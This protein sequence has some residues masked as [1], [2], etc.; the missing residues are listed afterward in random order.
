MLLLNLG[1]IDIME[2]DSKNIQSYIGSLGY[3][4][5]D[6]P[7]RDVVFIS[8][9]TGHPIL[10]DGRTR[11]AISL[12]ID[13]VNLMANIGSGYIQTNFLFSTGNWIYDTKLDTVYLENQADNLLIESGWKYQNNRWINE[14]GNV[15][16]FSLVV[17]NNY[18]D[19]V[20]AANTIAEQ[21]ANHGIEV[22]VI[23][24]GSQAFEYTFN[25]KAYECMICG[26]HTGFSPKITSL[27]NSNSLSN[28]YSE[29]LNNVLIDI[30]TTT[31]YS[32]Q[33]ENYSRL[34]DQYLKEFPYVFL[35]RSTSSV[36]YNQTLC[37][38]ISPNNYSMFYNIEKW[39]RQ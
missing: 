9:N 8:F 23:E 31:D 3:T 28:F 27:F 18:P 22:T 1:Y 30:K 32:K 34:Y 38:K 7:E 37:G 24:Q 35:Y 16:A 39:Y 11:K 29:D 19:R 25:N 2:V 13:R 20:V 4:K 33:K 26:I 36:I 17:D 6:I 12:Y 14:L 5:V 15:L 10:S 21:L